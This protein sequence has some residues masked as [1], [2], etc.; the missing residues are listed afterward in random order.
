MTDLDRRFFDAPDH[1][2]EAVNEAALVCEMVCVFF[3]V[4]ELLMP[5]STPSAGHGIF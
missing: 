3:A 4:L 5:S 2:S 1:R